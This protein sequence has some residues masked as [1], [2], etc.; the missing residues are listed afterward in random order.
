[1][2]TL[3]GTVEKTMEAE[4]AG[5]LKHVLEIELKHAREEN[6]FDIVLFLGVDGRIFASEVPPGLDAHQYRLLTLMKSNLGHICHQLRGQNLMLSIQQYDVGTIVISGV[7]D[8]AFLVF[9]AARPI[10]IAAMHDTLRAVVRVSAVM[11]HLLEERPVT[12][13][14]LAGYEEETARELRRLTRTLF[15]D[16]FEDTRGY[17]RNMEVLEFLRKRLESTVG[18]G[19]RDEILTMAFNEIGT[20]AAFMEAAS[21]DRLLEILARGVGEIAGESAAEAC[22]REWA[23]HV[24][25]ILASFV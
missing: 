9:L 3:A 16:T 8:K 19:S 24:H 14:A 25:K 6:A 22:R 17:K 18:V 10:E 4:S 1:M 20:S 11:K 5:L 7:G 12:P 21:W 15:V 23:P 13:A 2:P